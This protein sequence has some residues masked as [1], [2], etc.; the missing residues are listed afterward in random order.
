MCT[1]RFGS[2]RDLP[3]CVISGPSFANGPS[4]SNSW[5]A[6]WSSF[7]AQNQSAPQQY[8]WHMEGGGGDM[9]SSVA[10]Y[11]SILSSRGLATDRTININEYAVF[12]EEFA[13][14]SAWWIA[15]LERVN[16][17]GLRGNWLSGYALHDFMASLISKPGAANAYNPTAGG[18]FPTASWQVYKYYAQN[19]TGTRVQTSPTADLRGEVYAVVSDTT[20]RLLVGSRVATGTFN[21]QLQNLAAVGLPQSGTLNIHT[22][23]FTSSGDH[24]ARLDAPA[25]LGSYGHAYIGNT[26]SFP[27]YQKDA[28]T[29]YAFEF[30]R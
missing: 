10:N 20:V 26:L 25:D 2:R 22:W 17:F 14:G 1:N 21:I 8:S 18:Y 27:I 28:Y 3:G 13:A 7:I 30:S 4:N 9:Q 23:G 12:D 11:K 16:A 15:Q 5:W 29:A 19:M 6:S 24:Y